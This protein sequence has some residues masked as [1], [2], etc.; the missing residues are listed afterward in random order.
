MTG[1][2]KFRHQEDRTSHSIALV[3]DDGPLVENFTAKGR[4]EEG[5]MDRKSIIKTHGRSRKT[6]LDI[7]NIS[8]FAVI[9]H[10]I[11]TKKFTLSS[12]CGQKFVF[13]VCLKV[14]GAAATNVSASTAAVSAKSPGPK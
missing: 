5:S 3:D 12:H 4:M 6:L 8:Y 7:I 2:D 13:A 9:G 14:N 11:L 10:L 1:G